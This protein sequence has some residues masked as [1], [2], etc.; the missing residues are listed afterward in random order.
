MAFLRYHVTVTSTISGK[1]IVNGF[2]PSFK[3]QEVLYQVEKKHRDNFSVMM[4]PCYLTH[5][6]KYDYRNEEIR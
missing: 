5:L 4:I 6:E 2:F 1:I 3:I